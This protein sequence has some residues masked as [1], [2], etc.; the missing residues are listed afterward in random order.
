MDHAA[1]V[2]YTLHSRLAPSELLEHIRQNSYSC[3]MTASLGAMKRADY[4]SVLQSE[5]DCEIVLSPVSYIRNSERPD[6]LLVLRSGEQGVGSDID[7]IVLRS[8]MIWG[9]L[10]VGVTGLV[11]S[12]IIHWLILLLI[13]L[14]ILIWCMCR[15][16]AE[17]E[18]LELRDALANLLVAEK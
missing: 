6:L 9:I 2:E 17:A 4:T 11:F 13:P 16:L 5:S 14:G 3:Y 1:T 8:R 10:I 7:V 18:Q 15:R 12:L